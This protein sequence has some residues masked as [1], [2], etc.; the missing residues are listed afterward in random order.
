MGSSSWSDIRS[1]A[2]ILSG[3]L[4]AGVG[5]GLG[6]VRWRLLM[7]FCARVRYRWLGPAGEKRKQSK[8]DIKFSSSAVSRSVSGPL[9]SGALI[10]GLSAGLAS[11][12]EIA[13]SGAHVIN[14]APPGSQGGTE[15]KTSDVWFGF[16]NVMRLGISHP[17]RAATGSLVATAASVTISRPPRVIL[18]LARGYEIESP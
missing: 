10:S 12:L 17:R 3:K 11:L 9:A 6:L 1:F 5:S 2:E 18:T 13:P 16:T 4:S 8:L 14:S 15:A 7:R